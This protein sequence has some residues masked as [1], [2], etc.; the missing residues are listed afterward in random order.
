MSITRAVNAA[1]AFV[2]IT[3]RMAQRTGRPD[4]A[5]VFALS[6]LRARTSAIT[7]T[8]EG[9]ALEARGIDW[10]AISEV[11]LDGEYEALAPVLA[12]SERPTVLDLGANIGTFSAFIFARAPAATIHAYE[13]GS[14]S[15][16][17]LAGNAR[18]NP[19]FAW[20]TH[21]AAAW[22]SDGEIAFENS[23]ISTASRVVAEGGNE[24]VRAASLAT[25]LAR[26]GGRADLAKIDIEGAE[27]A[28][29]VAGT[30]ALAAIDT[31]VIEIHPN[32][33]SERTVVELLRAA[34]PRLY[35]IPGRKSA[36]PLLLATRTAVALALPV[37]EG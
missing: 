31:V 20:T 19:R 2:A 17:V 26:A 24:R 27:E 15:Y 30:G 16:A 28:V 32:R 13:P 12:A 37:Y 4:K 36:K 8:W 23:A 9:I 22:S 33:C 34:Y 25:I 35:R 3:A 18:R 14:A 5:A 21:H 1:K 7:F 6:A 11:L 10:P 29:L